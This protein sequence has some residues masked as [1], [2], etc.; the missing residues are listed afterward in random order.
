MIAFSMAIATLK[1]ATKR[2]IFPTQMH[3]Y[4]V[5][6]GHKQKIACSVLN[7]KGRLQDEQ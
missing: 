4:P 6:L 7:V 5:E 1:N 2:A 3:A